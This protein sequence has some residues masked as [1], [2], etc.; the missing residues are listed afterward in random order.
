M[1]IVAANT[2]V[3]P[4][5]ARTYDFVFEYLVPILIPLFLL[6]GDM[7]RI[8]EGIRTTVAFILASF[9]TV[10]GVLL[11]VSLLDL[12]AFAI[13]PTGKTQPLPVCSP[14]PTSAAR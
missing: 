5:Q 11:A 8:I 10:L 4:H 3:I 1:A 13:D 6:Q 14:P 2:G 7:R 9:G 12:S